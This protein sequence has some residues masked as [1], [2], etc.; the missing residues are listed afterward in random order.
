VLGNL[1]GRYIGKRAAQRGSAQMIARTKRSFGGSLA[2]F[3]LIMLL[4][5][6]VVC[7]G[8]MLD[9]LGILPV[10]KC[11]PVNFLPFEQW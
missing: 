11:A 10:V 5:F 2:G 6:A 3:C 4:I 7:L 1:Y 8:Q 9:G